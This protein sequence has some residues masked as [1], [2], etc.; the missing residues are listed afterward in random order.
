MIQN[1][2]LKNYYSSR[3]LKTLEAIASMVSTKLEQLFSFNE[4]QLRNNNL[5]RRVLN[6]TK[7]LQDHIDELENS[8]EEIQKQNLEE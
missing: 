4:L 5:E 6:K 3:D 2:D 7:R 1:I 8:Y